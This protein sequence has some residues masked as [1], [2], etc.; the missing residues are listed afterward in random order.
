[1]RLA[2]CWPLVHAP[3]VDS[4]D[5]KALQRGDADAWD[6][7][8]RWLWPVAFEVARGKLSPFLPADVE[9]A[10]IESLEEL[11]E[12]VREVKRVEELKPLLASIAHHRAVSRLREHFAA[13][14]GAGKTGS[15]E[16]MAYGNGD[17]FDAPGEDSPLTAL[18]QKDL[19]EGLGRLLAEL[20]PPTGEILSDF[21]LHRLSYEEIAQKRGVAMGS[22]GVY[23]KRGLE[24]M[25]RLWPRKGGEPL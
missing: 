8:F 10:A 3:R 24:T 25:R 16:A 1:M 2:R 18:E 12:K 23:L 17:A 11:V 19:A 9:D 14:R 4:P 21:F 15:L 13:K 7:A 20:K 5:L 22:V 6:E